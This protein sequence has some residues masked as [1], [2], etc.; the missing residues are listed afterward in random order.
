MM[1]S[2][3]LISWYVGYTG[4]T[5]V[6]AAILKEIL[7]LSKE[8]EVFVYLSKEEAVFEEYVHNY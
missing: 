5:P 6:R 7:Y 8:K 1:I 4:Q 2:H 3:G